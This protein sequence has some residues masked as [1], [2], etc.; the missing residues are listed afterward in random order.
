M[1]CFVD[2][3]WAKKPPGSL[4][5]ETE[6]RI[7]RR[8]RACREHHQR[9]PAAEVGASDAGHRV[10][11]PLELLTAVN[12]LL[13]DGP[14]AQR[15][16]AGIAA[17]VIQQRVRVR[18]R[19]RHRQHGHVRREAVADDHG[20]LDQPHG[21]RQRVHLGHGHPNLALVALL[22]GVREG[23]GCD[24]RDPSRPNLAL[25]GHDAQRAGV[26]DE[27][28]PDELPVHREGPSLAGL[29]AGG[30]VG[31]SRGGGAGPHDEGRRGDPRRLEAAHREVGEAVG[32]QDLHVA[33]WADLRQERAP[34]GL[35][36]AEAG[37]GDL[38]GVEEGNLAARDVQ[39]RHLVRLAPAEVRGRAPPQRKAPR[40]A[41]GAQGRAPHPA[42]SHPVL[43][44]PG[45]QDAP[46]LR[47]G[48]HGAERPA[49]GRGEL[50]GSRHVDGAGVVDLADDDPPSV[51][52]G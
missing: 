12:A 24:Q 43:V 18:G 28:A 3:L 36:V 33:C 7:V 13:G 22:I 41:L 38:V 14:R 6:Y 25:V 9:L 5:G 40:Q 19:V 23:V 34:E 48:D 42:R 27:V 45:D 30:G 49:R 17:P 26:E 1:I 8:A 29:R 35:R 2:W 31:V 4:L 37:G 50:D 10:A 39:R 20:A 15:H 11:Q 52:L 16:L 32:A 47:A 21:V 46:V 51:L 44:A